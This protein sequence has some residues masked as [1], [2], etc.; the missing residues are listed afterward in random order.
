MASVPAADSRM[1]PLQT[2]VVPG[3]DFHIDAGDPPYGLAIDGDQ[4]GAI[5]PND[6]ELL[7]RTAKRL[8]NDSTTVYCAEDACP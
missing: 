4:D 6:N 1:D 3:S 2:E 5:R 8:W 7:E